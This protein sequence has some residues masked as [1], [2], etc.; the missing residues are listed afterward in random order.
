MRASTAG[1]YCTALTV[2]YRPGGTW[3]RVPAAS[4]FCRAEALARRWHV[5]T[6]HLGQVPAIP[7]V[8]PRKRAQWK[9]A[10]GKATSP[11]LFGGGGS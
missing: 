6:V 2:L 11:L 10:A 5:G 1:T 8:G 3:A 9:P 7:T 4:P